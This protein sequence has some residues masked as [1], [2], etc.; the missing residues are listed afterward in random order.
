[1]VC[2]SEMEP[3]QRLEALLGLRIKMVG[4]GRCLCTSRW[5]HVALGLVPLCFCGSGHICC[6]FDGC[7]REARAECSI[8]SE[9]VLNP[10]G[11]FES[12]MWLRVEE[13]F[14][15]SLCLFFF[16][17]KKNLLYQVFSSSIT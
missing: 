17:R 3:H 8:C 13:G 1:M 12:L 7:V 11:E 5:S 6:S 4:D 10:L 9:F 14:I 16:L 15:Y 2:G